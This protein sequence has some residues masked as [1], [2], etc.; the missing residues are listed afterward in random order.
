MAFVDTE[1]GVIPLYPVQ[2]GRVVEVMAVE[3]QAY[4]AGKPLFRMDDTLARMQVEEALL[5][6][7][8]AENKLTQAR[9]LVEQHKKK[10]EAQRAKIALVQ[11]DVET[12]SVQHRKVARLYKDK[13]GG[14]KEDVE[15]AARVVDKAKAAVRAEEAVLATLET[16]DPSVAVKLM[17]LE[18]KA[19]QKQLEKARYGLTQCTVVAPVKGTVLRSLINVG[20]VLGSNPRQPVIQ[21]CQAGPRIIR[22]EVEQEF[23]GTVAVGQLARIEDD[24]TGGGDWRGKVMRISDWFTHRRSILMEPLQ[25][26]DVRTLE[27]IIR[28][29]PEPKTPLRIGQ[30]VRVTMENE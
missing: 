16:A 6:V 26:N 12:A 30:R 18:V 15:A 4:E 8:G 23:A 1:R 29:D 10:I 17:E 11:Q 27:V 19:K 3:G 2:P 5:A 20:E 28:F 14:S 25:F 13:V 22:A 9:L 7:S 21:F 24:S